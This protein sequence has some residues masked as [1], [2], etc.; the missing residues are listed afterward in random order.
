M[1]NWQRIKQQ[2]GTKFTSFPIDQETREESRGSKG[3]HA[4]R[5]D[6]DQELREDSRGRKRKHEDLDD[7]EDES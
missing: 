6:T 3:K 4:D 1:E 2:P 5:K 7:S